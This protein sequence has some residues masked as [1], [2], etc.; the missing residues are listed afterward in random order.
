MRFFLLLF[1]NMIWAVQFPNPP[2]LQSS[3]EVRLLLSEF[4]FCFALG[5]TSKFSKN[6]QSY[7]GRKCK[8]M[9][10]FWRGHKLGELS[11]LSQE[12]SILLIS[13]RSKPFN[14]SSK[15]GLKREVFLLRSC[16]SLCLKGEIFH[17]LFCAERQPCRVCPAL[18]FLLWFFN[19]PTQPGVNL[20]ISAV[21]TVIFR[22]F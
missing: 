8:C 22:N 11:I 6:N 16:L 7:G 9:F 5:S 10:R 1:L 3:S 19:L 15:S 17:F 21:R 18:A 4:F 12:L 13:A 14:V 20:S 2:A